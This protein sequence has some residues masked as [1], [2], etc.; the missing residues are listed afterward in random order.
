VT[1]QE[2]RGLVAHWQARL[3]LTEWRIRVEF[4]KIKPKTITMQVHRGIYQRATI[5]VNRWVL[6]GGETPKTWEGGKQ[7]EPRDI[8][9]AIV[10]ELLHLII[11]PLWI[12][13]NLLRGKIDN[14]LQDVVVGAYDRLEEGIVD[15]FAIALVANFGKARSSA[16]HWREKMAQPTFPPL[17]GNSGNEQWQRSSAH[18]AS[19]RSKEKLVEATT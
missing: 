12:W 14:D 9:E 19:G 5:H 13:A 11:G 10:H 1:E 7:I 8:E 15:K 16:L 17:K 3:G 4:T 2:I 18:D 6:P